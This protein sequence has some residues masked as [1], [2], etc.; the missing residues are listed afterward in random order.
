M[1][2]HL[3]LLSFVRR[4]RQVEQMAAL[5]EMTR[6]GVPRG[7]RDALD[8]LRRR[9]D[10]LWNESGEWRNCLEVIVLDGQLVGVVASG[11]RLRVQGQPLEERQARQHALRDICPVASGPYQLS[12]ANEVNASL[13]LGIRV[14]DEVEHGLRLEIGNFRKGDEVV[15]LLA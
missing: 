12:D 2:C 8:S 4:D 15:D 3:K 6:R 11:R 14:L 10:G 5:L 13:L 1:R 7:K 9:A